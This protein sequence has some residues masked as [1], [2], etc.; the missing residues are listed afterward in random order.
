MADPTDGEALTDLRRLGTSVA[1][2]HGLPASGA[3]PFDR[4]AD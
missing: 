1:V 4:F 3:P 2:F